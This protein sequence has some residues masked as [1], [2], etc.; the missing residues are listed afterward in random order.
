MRLKNK[1][2]EESFVSAKD[3]V[4]HI[5][6]A[7]GTAV[8]KAPENIVGVFSQSLFRTVCEVRG[9]E[10]IP[11]TD[12]KRISDNIGLVSMGIGA[13]YATV[14]MEE[15]IVCG[16]KNFILVG[17]AGGLKESLSP[18]YFLIPTKAARDEGVSRHYLKETKYSAPSR[19]LRD[20]IVEIFRCEEIKYK[21]GPVWTTDAIYRETAKEIISYKNEGILAVEMEDAALYAV[22]QYRGANAASI[23]IISDLLS[24]D[25]WEPHFGDKEVRNAELFG[26]DIAV[27]TFET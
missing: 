7:M 12:I 19:S 10:N 23:H 22:A 6:G 11:G 13:P 16:A 26:V 1:H 4:S 2:E 8:P 27:K 5:Y 20:A 14:N 24:V 17:T 9:C 25:K 15:L 3:F 21:S 18:G